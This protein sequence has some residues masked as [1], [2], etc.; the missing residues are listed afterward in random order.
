MLSRLSAAEQLAITGAVA[1]LF[2]EIVFGLIL[3]EY[4]LGQLTWLLA[5][6]VLV[7]ASS[8][9]PGTAGPARVCDGRSGL[10]VRRRSDV[11]R[12]RVRHPGGTFDEVAIVAAAIY[13]RGG[14]MA[15]RLAAQGG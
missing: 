14:A 2:V 8:A 12:P 13:Y 15:A 1:I 7:A 4:F 10:R 3:Y 9:T 5:V 6:A 11:G